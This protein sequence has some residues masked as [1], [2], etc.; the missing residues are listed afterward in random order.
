MSYFKSPDCL[1]SYVNHRYQVV[2][3]TPQK[4][5]DYLLSHTEDEFI[6]KDQRDGEGET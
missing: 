3:G 6:G 4:M 5:L 1:Q 2:K